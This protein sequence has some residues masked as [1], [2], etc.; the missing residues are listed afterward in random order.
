MRSNQE[1]SQTSSWVCEICEMN[2][3]SRCY[4]TTVSHQYPSLTSTVMRLNRM[5]DT[6]A[7]RPLAGA[8]GSL[9]PSSAGVWHG[10]FRSVLQQIPLISSYHVAG[11]NINNLSSSRGPFLGERYGG[12]PNP[13]A[14]LHVNVYIFL[15]KVQETYRMEVLIVGN[16]M[17]RRCSETRKVI[18]PQRRSRHGH[19]V[20]SVLKVSSMLS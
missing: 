2:L 1:N 12:K 7:G 5:Q 16:L 4:L 18:K 14:F 3:D 9:L 17:F 8:S 6:I 11:K 20:V 15:A 19:A 13:T 10:E